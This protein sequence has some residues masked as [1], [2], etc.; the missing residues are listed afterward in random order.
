M[1]NVYKSVTF[2]AGR[3][4]V[5][6]NNRSTSWTGSRFEKFLSEFFDEIRATAIKLVSTVFS[7]NINYKR[8]R[9]RPNKKNV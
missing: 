7:L 2:K 5:G 3:K 1:T 4:S 8:S 9:L 6:G